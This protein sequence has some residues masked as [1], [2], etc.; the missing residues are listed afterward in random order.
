MGETG[1]LKDGHF[2]NLEVDG[3]TIMSGKLTLTNVSNVNRSARTSD[4]YY[5]DEYFHQLPSMESPVAVT[6]STT[7]GTAVTSHNKHTKITTASDGS[8][9]NPVTWEEFKFT[10]QLITANS[11]VLLTV[12]DAA[13][14]NGAEIRL[15][16]SVST[17]DAGSCEI[18]A[19]NNS[20]GTATAQI[21]MLGIIIDPHVPSNLNLCIADSTGASAVTAGAENAGSACDESVTWGG[22]TSLSRAGINLKTS[23]RTGDSVTDKASVVLLPR[24]MGTSSQLMGGSAAGKPSAWTGVLWGTENQV[25][26][27][28]ALSIANKDNVAFWAGLKITNTPEIGIDDDQIY[29]IYD[30]DDSVAGTLATN[31]VLHCVCSIGDVDNVSAL[32]IT[33]ADDFIY[34]LKIIIH[35]DRTASIFVNGVQYNVTTGTTATGD[36]V[37]PGT[38]RSGVLTDNV[39]LNPIIGVQSTTAAAD[40]LTIYYQAINRY[41]FE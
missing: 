5:L 8:A 14:D 28:C 20:A 12:I 39:D 35:S 32:D 26:W 1:C 21:Y 4:R 15:D 31:T 11:I 37:T 10:N 34:R 16:F 23:A 6:Q 17:V 38:T 13:G 41:L 2:Q 25:E 9:V 24:G 40:T 7:L 22:S 3:N 27:E 30:S 36:S 29:F 19:V 18:R 33:V